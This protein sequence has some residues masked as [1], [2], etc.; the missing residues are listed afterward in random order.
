MKQKKTF[1]DIR[2][3]SAEV[4]KEIKDT[5]KEKEL[6]QKHFHLVQIQ[7]KIRLMTSGIEK[8]NDE[9]G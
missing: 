6:L 5:E 7:K 1:K 2:M 8:L 3:S 9:L 4:N